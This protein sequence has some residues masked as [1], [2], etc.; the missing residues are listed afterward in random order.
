MKKLFLTLF[1]LSFGVSLSAQQLFVEIF[2]GYNKTAFELEK[3]SESVHFFPIGG[4]LAGGLEHAQ[5]GVEYRQN[6]S[7][8]EFIFKN[9]D[10]PAKEIQKDEFDMQY[11]G[12]FLRGNV[13]KIP[14]YRFGLIIKAGAGYYNHTLKQ[15]NLITNQTIEHAYDKIMGFN[16]GIGVSS[17]IYALLHWEI[18]YQFNMVRHPEEGPYEA[19]NAFY[20]SLQVGLS[21]NFVFGN[22]AKRC[23]RVLHSSRRGVL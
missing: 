19:Y 20:H 2:S 8:P 16:A 9:T 18:G 22:T 6:L 17:P 15:H 3:Y 14:A 10:K 21:M 11:Y 12:L 23:R 7:N 1:V 4:R 13:S 5:I